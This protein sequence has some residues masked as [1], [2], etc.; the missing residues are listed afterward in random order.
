MC[1]PTFYRICKNFGFVRN[2]SGHIIIILC[3]PLR[4]GIVTL[5]SGEMS[6]RQIVAVDFDASVDKT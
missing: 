5:K 3:N 2:N 6:R 4:P 1:R